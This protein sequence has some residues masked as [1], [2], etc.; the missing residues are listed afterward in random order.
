[1]HPGEQLPVQL[2]HSLLFVTLWVTGFRRYPIR[3]PS[4]FTSLLHLFVAKARVYNY[5]ARFEKAK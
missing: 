1:M 5:L 2:P 3:A 4:Y